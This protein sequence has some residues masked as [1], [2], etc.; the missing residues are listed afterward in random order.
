[1]T[2]LPHDLRLLLVDDE[3]EFLAAMTP[4]LIRRG[5]QVRVAENGRAALDL[6]RTETVDVVVLDVKMP[7]IDGVETFHEIKRVAPGL[8]V[9]LLTGHGSIPQAF[10]TSR[11]G[12]ANYLAKPCDVERLADAARQAVADRKPETAPSPP[13]TEDIHLLLVDDDRDFTEAL[14]P[15]LERRG[16]RVTAP[17]SGAQALEEVG[18]RRFDVAIVDVRMP[19]MDGLT[20]LR[21]L[22]EVDPRL[23]VIVLTGHP[24][25]DDVRR[26]LQEGAFDYLTKPQRVEDVVSRVQAAYARRAA[27]EEENRRAEADQILSRHPD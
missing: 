17:H 27:R 14:V 19:D 7:G 24:S 1:M 11:A 18:V 22:R 20:L 3:V 4:G 16:V 12:V 2:A 21:W 8:P 25:V 26:G 13:I 6:L 15:A 9:I 23:E 5:F 10:E